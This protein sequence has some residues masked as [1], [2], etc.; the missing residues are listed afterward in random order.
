M[1]G[2]GDT[3]RPVDR[4]RWDQGYGRIFNR[5]EPM[6]QCIELTEAHSVWVDNAAPHFGWGAFGDATRFRVERGPEMAGGYKEPGDAYECT[7][8]S[9][10]WPDKIDIALMVLGYEPGSDEAD[11][12]MLGL[13]HQMALNEVDDDVDGA[14]R[15]KLLD[16]V[17]VAPVWGD[18]QRTRMVFVVR[19][20]PRGTAAT[21]TLNLQRT[22]PGG[23]I[24]SQ[25][26][27]DY[28][29]LLLDKELK[30]RD[31]TFTEDTEEEWLRGQHG[32]GRTVGETADEVASQ[33]ARGPA[34][35]DAEPD[36]D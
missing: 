20:F 31:L 12:F 30:S 36:A 18:D 8:M 13:V 2:K 1:A 16:G 34:T 4:G 10:L 32:E 11:Q 27:F 26:S 35:V 3:Y 25:L 29:R 19:A 22:V 7:L 33:R 6:F 23:Q 21:A 9:G 17:K 24:A 28:W 5:R 14:A 15:T